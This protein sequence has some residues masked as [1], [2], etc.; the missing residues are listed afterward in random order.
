VL[1]ALSVAAYVIF[2]AEVIDPQRYEQYKA[3]TP[4]CIAA[5]GGRFVV[6]GGEVEVL[7]GEPPAGRTVVLEFPSMH[8]ARAWYASDEYTEIRQLRAG[9]ARARA[10][11]V[12]GVD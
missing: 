1:G 3:R 6:R 9:A 5:H 8:A 4:A 10:Y 12:D 2:Q 11:I 7:E